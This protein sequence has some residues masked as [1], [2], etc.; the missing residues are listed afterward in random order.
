MLDQFIDKFIELKKYSELL[1]VFKKLVEEHPKIPILWSKLSHAYYWI[2]ER[3]NALQA[4]KEGLI[5]YRFN[6][7]AIDG[8]KSIINDSRTDYF[9]VVKP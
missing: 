6:Y 1:S 4:Y 3:Y 2:G 7:E 8:T 9:S 5:L